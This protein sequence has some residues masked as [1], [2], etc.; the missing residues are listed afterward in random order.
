VAAD[1]MK[2]ALDAAAA[3]DLS[4]YYVP[5]AYRSWETQNQY[6]QNR[7]E[8][9]SSKYSGDALIEA[10]KKEVN[11]PGTSEYNTGLSFRLQLYDRNDKEIINTK[12][13]TS[14]QGVWMNQHCWEY[15]L[16]FR[17]PQNAW[18][19]ETSTDKSFV[20]GIR[21]QM[22]LYRYV[23]KGNAAVMHAM[24]FC[25]EE[26]IQYLEEHPHVA[27]FEDGKLRYEIYRQYVGEANSFDITVTGKAKS[28]VSSL[29]N[30]GGVITV[31]EY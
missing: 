2:A 29:D 3:E 4:H 20:T 11:Y 18:P 12:Y 9:L 22:N 8:K 27:L 26:Y 19:L 24:D 25:L 30:M 21:S 10:A 23:G 28:Y 31:F 16:V 15:G 17:F 1:A 13:S 6:F 7:V 14:S 5:E